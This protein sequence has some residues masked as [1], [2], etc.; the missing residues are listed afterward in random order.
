MVRHEVVEPGY[1]AFVVKSLGDE[2]RAWLTA[3]PRVLDELAD[4]W[5]LTLGG[6]LPGGLLSCVRT[7]AL[8]DGRHAVLKVGA[9]RRTRDEIASLTAWAG[10]STPELLAADEPRQAL[11][12]ER[13]EPGRHPDPARPEDVAKVLEGLRAPAPDGLPTLE[14]AVE[15]RI[16]TAVRDGRASPQKADWA[17]RTAARLAAA[18][19]APALVHGDLDERNLLVCRRRGLCAVDPLPCAGD[20][21]YD[22]GTWVHG[23]RRPGRRARLDAIVAATGLDRGR[24]RVWAAVVGVHG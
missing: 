18:A 14:A 13:I 21:A 15:E 22:A 16:E 17:R 10:R 12:L 5:E 7:A 24:V 11:L 6:E 19:P 3:L 23:N 9:S 2:G 8:A 20:P 4:E 1:R